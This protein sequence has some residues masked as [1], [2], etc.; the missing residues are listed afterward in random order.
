MAKF[1]NLLWGMLA[2]LT[3]ILM[4]GCGEKDNPSRTSLEVDTSDLVLLIGESATRTATSKAGDAV[5]TYSSS[6]PAVA[7]VDQNGKVTGVSAGNATITVSMDESRSSWYAANSLTYKVIVQK[8]VSAVALKN[9]DKSTPL[10]L[11][12]DEDGKITVYFNGGIT[13]AN[14]IKYTVNG[15]TE[16]TIAKNTEGSYDIVLKKGDMVQ[17]YS[18]NTSLGGGSVAGAR[19]FTRAVAEGSQHINIRPSMKTEIFG[20][21]MSL[22]KGKDNLESATAIEAPN[23]FYGLFSGAD[24]LVNSDDRELVLPATTLKEGCYDNMFS[25]CKGIEKAPELPAPTLVKDCYSGMFSGC[26]K[27]SEV[28]CLA[29]DVSADGCVK[30][31]LADAGKEA[32]TPPVIEVTKEAKDAI[33]ESI[34]KEFTPVI[35]ISKITVEPTSLALTVGETATLKATVEPAEAKDKPIQWESDNIAVATVSADGVVTAEGSGSAIIKISSDGTVFAECEVKVEALPVETP[36]IY[37]VWVYGENPQIEAPFS[38]GEWD[39]YAMRFSN[40]SGDH[41]RTLTD[42]EYYGLKT[43]IVDVSDATND[44][45]MRVMTGWW[46]PVYADDIPVVNGKMKIQITDEMADD[47]AMGG[48]G[49]N[50]TLMLKKGSC[51]INSVYYE[52]EGEEKPQAQ[53]LA[54]SLSL[55]V[56]PQGTV[57]YNKNHDDT[58]HNYWAQISIL[59]ENATNKYVKWTTSN[60]NVFVVGEN[61][62]IRPIS[63]GVA[64]VTATAT[65]GSNLSAQCEVTVKVVGSIWYEAENVTKTLGCQPFINPLS[66]KGAGITSI[67][68]SSSDESKAKVNA[69]TGEVTVVD[70]ATAGQVVIKATAT[71]ADEIQYYYYSDDEKSASYTLNLAPATTQGE[72]NDYS[73]GSW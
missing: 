51:T 68:Y 17:L 54:T 43:L 42:E 36:Q 5:I 61:G 14:D 41:F 57:Y 70:G 12:A 67:T 4:V 40:Q 59:P 47:C 26:S 39:A 19:G 32:E 55:A 44:C 48:G 22:L 71:V 53:I 18:N 15:G 13:L 37:K 52:E 33:S 21:V 65:D 60:P 38:A 16:Q 50:L 28:K 56:L 35:A 6:D 46:N 62:S 58:R 66:Q 10:T 8:A 64:T 23:A 73:P 49:R 1:K 20:N 72:R 30:D 25:G 63:D 29:T 2:M 45:S 31:W 24:K 9:A 69:T 3:T 11:V 7:T 27:L 34:P